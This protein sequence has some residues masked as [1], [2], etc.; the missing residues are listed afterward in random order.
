MRLHLGRLDA[1]AEA[2]MVAVASRL[3]SIGADVQRARLYGF[4]LRAETVPVHTKEGRST[5]D[6]AGRLHEYAKNAD[7]LRV[8]LKVS[9]Q[10]ML[11]AIDRA[12]RQ[13]AQH[14]VMRAAAEAQRMREERGGMI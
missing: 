3:I 12:S 1:R 6:A 10:P 8:A 7:A 5:R 13:L 11:D 4:R 2:A 14:P 9:F